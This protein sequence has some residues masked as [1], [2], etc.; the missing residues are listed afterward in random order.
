[1]MWL[2]YLIQ[3]LLKWAPGRVFLE[4][5]R[6]LS[7]IQFKTHFIKAKYTVRA[8]KLLLTNCVQAHDDCLEVLTHI[9]LYLSTRWSRTVGSPGHLTP[10]FLKF[11][12]SKN[13]VFWNS[14]FPRILF[15]DQE[16]FSKNRRTISQ[17]NSRVAPPSYGAAPLPPRC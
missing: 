15:Q 11:H 16:F 5:T 6:I 7:G 3:M 10:R 4:R 9:I 13:S 2:K 17:Q 12:I 14:I 1:M 8:C